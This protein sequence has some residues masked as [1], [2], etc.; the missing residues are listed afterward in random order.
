MLLRAVAV[1]ETRGQSARPVAAATVP[2]RKSRR[3]L[4]MVSSIVRGSARGFPP[5]E[6][7]S[8]ARSSELM[9]ERIVAARS[10]GMVEFG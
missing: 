7:T 10:P 3:E 2:L 5:F 8:A 6:P 9:A 1:F 4:L